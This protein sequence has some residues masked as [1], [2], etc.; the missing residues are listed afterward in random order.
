M[1]RGSHPR[2][3]VFRK[4]RGTAPGFTNPN[5]HALV[6]RAT[7]QRPCAPADVTA[8]VHGFASGVPPRHRPVARV[9]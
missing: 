1:A 5:L 2:G 4:P 7:V 3:L 8:D 6:I 9:G